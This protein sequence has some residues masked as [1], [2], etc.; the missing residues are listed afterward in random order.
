MIYVASSW[1]NPSQ[2]AL[3]AHLK[4]LGHEVYYPRNPTPDD[5]GFHGRMSV[6]WRDIDPVWKSWNVAG[7]RAGLNHKLATDAYKH[8]MDAL[9]AADAVVLLLPGGRSSHAEAG[10]AVGAGKPVYVMVPP[11]QIVEPELS[12]KMFRGITDDT[13]ELAMWL[14]RW[15]KDPAPHQERK[16]AAMT[17][18]QSNDLRAED[19]D[20]A[21][22][23]AMAA[24]KISCLLKIAELHDI[25]EALKSGNALIKKAY[26]DA[27]EK[28]DETRGEDQDR[29]T[30]AALAQIDK[31][32]ARI[33]VLESE[34]KK[35]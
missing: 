35:Q 5:H 33:R 4:N 11:N 29:I 24:Q 34:R 25:I 8:D 18:S 2:P 22:L 19:C 32:N 12:Y 7:F 31:L 16:G 26:E 15:V 9:K 23:G 21:E 17:T 10:W 27:L 14:L 6:Y 28:C 20:G 30:S 13:T 1:R 3:V